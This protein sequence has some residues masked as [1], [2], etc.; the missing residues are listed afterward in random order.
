MN[1][2]GSTYVAVEPDLFQSQDGE[3]VIAFGRDSN[4]DTYLFAGAGAN[5][6]VSWYEA[7]PV[8]FDWWAGFCWSFYR[9]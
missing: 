3:S 1:A 6:K 5:V 8:Q 7:Q 4:Q 2:Y 9:R